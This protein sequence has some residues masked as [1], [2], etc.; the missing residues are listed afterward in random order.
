MADLKLALE[1]TRDG[2]R[3]AEHLERFA[4]G[5]KYWPMI[6]SGAVEQWAVLDFVSPGQKPSKETNPG[7]YTIQG[8]ADWAKADILHQGVALTTVMMADTAADM[9]S[10]ALMMWLTRATAAAQQLGPP[11]LTSGN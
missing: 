11:P 7:H 10:A 3:L 6:S 1:L 5:G 9:E 8:H 4:E 2:D